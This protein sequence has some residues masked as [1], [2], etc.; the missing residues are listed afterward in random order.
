MISK[1]AFSQQKNLDKKLDISGGTAKGSLA[2][3]A[4]HALKWRYAGAI[5]QAGLQFAIGIILARLLSPEAFG[6]VGMALIAIGFGRLIGDLG[7]AAA[8]I[9]YPDVTPRHVRTAFTGSLLVGMLLFVLLW[10]LAPAIS[11]LFNQPVL[12][13]MLR[14]TGASLVVS[15]ISVISAGLLRR[16]LRFRLLTIIETVSYV[17]GFGVVGVSMALLG[18]G[19]W[20]L[21]AANIAQ[22]L[23]L[24]VLAIIFGRQPLRPCLGIREYRDLSRVASG[25]MLNNIVNYAAE[26]LHFF[27]IGKWMGASALG[28]FNRS[29]HLMHLPVKHFSFALGSVMFPLYAKMQGDV[30]RLGRAFLHTVSLTALVT[31]PVFFA[32][33]AVPEIV[34]GGLFGAQWKQAAASFQVLCVCGPF[35]AMMRVFGTVSHARG[36][37]FSECGRQVIYLAFVSVA[38]WLLFPY[39]LEGLALAV[40]IAIVTR[41]L[42]LA[43]LA[44]ELAG[45]QWRQFVM[46]QV[47]GVGL[48]IVVALPVYISSA[49]GSIVISSD[50]LMLVLIVAVAVAAVILSFLILPSSWFGDSYPWLVERFGPKL[51][52]CLRKLLIEK[53]PAR[54]HDMPNMKVEVEI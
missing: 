30:P 21:I 35:M 5:I 47:P 20:S 33:A 31:V 9:Q 27:V 43:H 44:L 1:L 14:V 48:G 26:N 42:L 28:L 29:Y 37:V 40:A 32:M 34:I 12:T 2:G 45:V 15:G 16:E 6:V 7:F 54:R 23:C 4:F 13:A 46:A 50:V 53:L 11:G 3:A 8:I 38:L 51:P 10:V 17:V 49:V 18:Y 39:G 52:H 22:P 36:Y 25:E 24:F 41:Y 19:A